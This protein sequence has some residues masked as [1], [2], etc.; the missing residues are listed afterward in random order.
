MKLTQEQK[1]VIVGSLLG[2]GNLQTDTSGRTWRYRAL[3]KA[4]HLLYLQYKYDCLKNL[5]QTGI[6]YHESKPDKRTGKIAK[7]YY[8]NTIVLV[9]L[10]HYGNLFYTYDPKLGQFVKDVPKTVEQLLS[11]RALAI[12]YQERPPRSG[13]R[14]DGAL[15]WKGKSKAML[16]CTE[17][18]SEEGVRRLKSAIKN[19]YNIETTLSAK[20]NSSGLIVGYRLSIPAASSAAFVSLIEPFLINCMKYKVNVFTK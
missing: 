20:K 2:D 5:C 11:P 16:I 13:G 19:L 12:M 15:K 8:F 6:I 4:D 18:F 10:R 7:R 9:C 17:S 3:H 1:D 14:Y